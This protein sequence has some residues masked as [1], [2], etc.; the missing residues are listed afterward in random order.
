MPIAYFRLRLASRI[1]LTAPQSAAYRLGGTGYHGGSGDRT[2]G[3]GHLRG[4]SIIRCRA[5]AFKQ[6]TEEVEVTAQRLLTEELARQ[7]GFLV[8]TVADAR[9]LQTNYS[10]AG[11]SL[12]AE[13]LR[14][15]GEEAHADVVVTGRLV[16]YGVVRWQ[17]W[18]PGLLVSMLTETQLLAKRPD[19]IRW[20]W[21]S[22]L[23]VNC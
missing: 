4:T 3:L 21:R 9:R 2:I 22:P 18:V 6:L 15:L 1:L 13:G 7:P 14:A 23:L 10:I 8:V 11:N 20:P 19:L 17:Y 12:D 16:D 5:P